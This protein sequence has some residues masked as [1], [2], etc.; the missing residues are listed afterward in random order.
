ML[1]LLHAR[2]HH[3]QTLAAKASSKSRS[4]ASPS[5]LTVDRVSQLAVVALLPALSCC[6]DAGTQR[7]CKLLSELELLRHTKSGHRTAAKAALAGAAQCRV[8]SRC[9]S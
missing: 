8:K 9:A 3:S 5:P 2:R 1:R 7:V 6:S 4:T